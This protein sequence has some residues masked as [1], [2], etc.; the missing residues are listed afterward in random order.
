MSDDSCDLAAI[1]R[2]LQALDR[3]HLD[4][5]PQVTPDVNNVNDARALAVQRLIK[6][7]PL[8]ESLLEHE[9]SSD[10]DPFDIDA[11]IASL[12]S[13]YPGQRPADDDDARLMFETAR[14]VMTHLVHVKLAPGAPASRDDQT[15][16][17]AQSKSGKLK[18]RHYE[19]NLVVANIL[20]ALELHLD[21]TNETDQAGKAVI[22]QPYRQMIGE[23]WLEALANLLRPLANHVHPLVQSAAMETMCE[24]ISKHRPNKNALLKLLSAQGLSEMIRDSR[25]GFWAVSI[26][27]LAYRLL[28][29][30]KK[31]RFAYIETLTSSGKEFGGPDGGMQK[32]LLSFNGGNYYEVGIAAQQSGPTYLRDKWLPIIAAGSYERAQPFEIST[33]ALDGQVLVTRDKSRFFW[34]AQDFLETEF[35]T[36]TDLTEPSSAS[37]PKDRKLYIPLQN[38]NAIDV[39]VTSE[40]GMGMLVLTF[41]LSCAPEFDMPP[42]EF[43]VEED[44]SAG[45][46]GLVV[47]LK[48]RQE[49]MDRI[50]GTFADRG[51][52]YATFST[53]LIPDSIDRPKGVRS[54]RRPRARTVA[55]EAPMGR[56]D[57]MEADGP[58]GNPGLDSKIEENDPIE[59]FDSRKVQSQARAEELREMADLPQTGLEAS[60]NSSS[61]LLPLQ[62][63]HDVHTR[64]AEPALAKTQ[65]PIDVEVGGSVEDPGPV[66]EESQVVSTE[67]G[68]DRTDAS[69][70]APRMR[71]HPSSPRSDAPEPQ[72]IAVTVIQEY[73]KTK[74]TPQESKRTTRSSDRKL[75]GKNQNKAGV[76]VTVEEDKS[77]SSLSDIAEDSDDADAPRDTST[78][79]AKFRA[80]SKALA[81]KA[82][83]KL[84]RVQS[85]SHDQPKQKMA[86]ARKK[87]EKRRTKKMKQVINDSEESKESTEDDET[88]DYDEAPLNNRQP[89]KAKQLK[90]MQLPSPG[91]SGPKK[92]KFVTAVV[93]SKRKAPS[94]A[95]ASSAKKASLRRSKRMKVGPQDEGRVSASKAPV[96]DIKETHGLEHSESDGMG[97]MEHD[98]STDPPPHAPATEMT[99]DTPVKGATGGPQALRV[100]RARSTE[101][102]M[103]D[104]ALDTRFVANAL[105][106]DTSGAERAFSKG[107]KTGETRGEKSY[108]QLPPD[109]A[110]STKS[111]LER[112]LHEVSDQDEDKSSSHSVGS[113]SPP[114]LRLGDHVLGET[115]QHTQRDGMFYNAE[116]EAAMEQDIDGG[117]HTDVIDFIDNEKAK[118]KVG[119]PDAPTESDRDDRTE[120]IHEAE[121]FA[122]SGQPND[123]QIRHRALSP[124]TVATALPQVRFEPARVGLPSS[125]QRD[126]AA[127]SERGRHRG[128]A[129]TWKA[130]SHDPFFSNTGISS[131]SKISDH[132]TKKAVARSSKP[133]V[134]SKRKSKAGP[135]SAGRNVRASSAPPDSSS[136]LSEI[137]KER[138]SKKIRREPA[139]AARMNFKS[140]F[141]NQDRSS[142]IRSQLHGIVEIILNTHESRCE[143]QL[144][145]LTA[146]QEA[147]RVKGW[148]CSMPILQNTHRIARAAERIHESTLVRM[149]AMGERLIDLEKT[150]AQLVGKLV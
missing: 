21:I 49:V 89:I 120:S 137:T 118:T 143:F 24:L 30:S 117:K 80:N 94:P 9:S 45:S 69:I 48:W 43:V 132:R 81:T 35:E 41:S 123:E 98:F 8:L 105:A 113:P 136:P 144:E 67:E 27:E 3:H 22:N 50:R 77:M 1:I 31:E 2:R 72:P 108:A 78:L 28:P 142:G 4:A 127:Q 146:A 54:S 40:P 52:R 101:S 6:L 42:T 74:D 87:V 32:D 60:N 15:G 133:M 93:P 126:A 114:P 140:A 82:S 95:V 10:V 56:G 33:L 70:N 110:H 59:S 76:E 141:A 125:A 97:G 109:K 104:P 14:A 84:V 73:S 17:S 148:A 18:Q 44:E 112:V 96:H 128:L 66:E 25:D 71:S 12:K 38:I 63:V 135:Q 147:I 26:F 100:A 107:H 58:V 150:G 99:A 68:E 106:E 16:R 37:T 64:A 79:K 20:E 23:L 5:T 19:W 55:I 134:S 90:G 92:K 75:M 34:I 51:R 124:L 7:R 36:P 116:E 145:R 129:R 39:D 131:R 115:P 83:R 57:S 103:L 149:K 47:R 53:S 62:E 122:L 85:P 13:L 65:V 61:F 138:R 46:Y 139:T 11:L 111:N 86:K 119:I 102:T 91:K 121:E 29:A 130:P 88:T